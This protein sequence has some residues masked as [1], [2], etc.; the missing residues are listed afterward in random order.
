MEQN[1]RMLLKVLSS[2]RFLSRKG[3]ALRGHDD[4]GDGNLIQV[5]RLLGEDD[6]EVSDWLQKKSNKYTSPGIQNDLIAILA[7]R[8][9]RSITAL[10]QESPFL[11][12]MIDEKTDVHKLGASCHC[13]S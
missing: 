2:I 11:A 13:D 1:K 9:L 12:V 4:D 10:L 6:G 7:L 8:I 5:L 3:L